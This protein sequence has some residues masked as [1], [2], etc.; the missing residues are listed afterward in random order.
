MIRAGTAPWRIVM[1]NITWTGHAGDDLFNDGANWSSGTV[2]GSGD[3]AVISPSAAVDI[4]LNAAVTVGALTM[5]KDV[6]LTVGDSTSA[7]SFTIG[8]SAGAST[9]SNA[10]VFALD[11]LGPSADL[12]VGATSLTLSGT[13]TILLGGLSN[14]TV[15]GA[16]GASVLN[17]TGNLIEGAG[18][19]GAGTLT[20]IN[21]AAGVVDADSQAGLVLNTGTVTISN[22]GLLEATGSGG[23]TLDSNVNNGASGK[24]TAAGGDVYAQGG[25]IS[26]GTLSAS[27]G[28]TIVTTNST[29][30]GTAHE[31]TIDGN[32]AVADNSSLSVLGTIANT[33][34][35]AM[36]ASHG[37][38]VTLYVGPTAAAGTT[39]LTGAGALALSDDASNSVVAGF[40][41][42]TLV[43]LNN[44]IS[45]A[46]QIGNGGSLTIVNDATI[47]ANGVDTL[48]INTADTV[49][50]NKLI[51]ATGRGGLL[52]EATVQ[53]AK[54]TISAAGGVVTLQNADIVGGLLEASGGGYILDNSNLT[55]DGTKGLTN[56]TTILAEANTNLSLLG[57]LTNDGTLAVAASHGYGVNLYVGPSA[58]AGTM[59]LT[60]S[61]HVTLSDDAD[62]EI[63]AAGKGDTLVNLNNT[64][65]GAGQIGNGGSLTLIN[66]ATINA[67]GIDTLI[68]NSADLITN[69]KLIEATGSGGLNLT[70]TFENGASG[71][72][73]AAG[74]VIS[75]LGADI[76]GGVLTQSSLGYFADGSSATLD[77]SVNAITNDATILAVANTNLTLLGTLTNA[78]TISLAASHGYGTDL[79]V[80]PGGTAGT[81]TLTG[82]GVLTLS[83]DQ[84]NQILANFAGDTLVN[85]NNIISGAGNIGNGGSLTLINGGTINANGT[86]GLVI[87]S[88][89]LTTNNGLME[90]T[91][92]GGLTIDS[93]VANS[94][95]GTISVTS[96]LGGGALSFLGPITNAGTIDAASGSAFIT[97]TVTGT[98]TL[99]IGATGT[100]S[101]LDGAG[102]GQTAD[103]LASTGALDLTNPLQF[104]GTIAGFGGSD[105]IDLVST[106][107]TTWGFANGTLTVKD[108][109]ATVAS[110]QFSGS[111]TQGSFIVGADGHGGTSVTFS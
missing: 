46:G 40:A 60:G 93:A 62:N 54:G 17:N 89:L 97:Q 6:T 23:L 87:N 31:L 50:N 16:T 56:K 78:G 24:I 41:G 66:D 52:L 70:G 3:T 13:G 2:P 47:D 25:T 75:L 59:T 5:A 45:G 12:V 82:S 102:T 77:G 44:T 55:L 15:T 53:D 34:T 86:N 103:F 83:D 76:E 51:E 64:I 105:V 8:T 99:A 48:V 91:G 29:L 28:C 36:L 43:N 88:A 49:T 90:A 65:S 4:Y 7:L 69:T 38:G 107:E 96:G 81:M 58:G 80:G 72:L 20:F 85:L 18:Q 37:Y 71:T 92:G 1:T 98:G 100:L 14:N 10:G 94:A 68:I 79:Y 106:P 22:S 57:T 61:G 33:G 30:N 19:L 26:G 110:L 84:N 108:G 95:T 63:L 104:L 32:V 35:I 11:S 27:A 67:N 39:T 101:L 111:Y 109:N 74:G 9:F 42:D 73:A 21:G